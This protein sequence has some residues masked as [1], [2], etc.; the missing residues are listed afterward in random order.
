MRMGFHGPSRQAGS[1]A[2]AAWR[3]SVWWSGFGK[4]TIQPRGPRPM[5]ERTQSAGTGQPNRIR[6]KIQGQLERLAAD[7][8]ARRAQLAGL[9]R[10]RHTERVLRVAAK[11]QVGDI[12]EDHFSQAGEVVLGERFECAIAI[13]FM[14]HVFRLHA[15]NRKIRPLLAQCQTRGDTCVCG[16]RL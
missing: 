1:A 16:S 14:A 8:A 3:P 12:E 4:V 6:A 7:R 2:W 15:G 11:I 9:Q 10:I 5:V 13:L